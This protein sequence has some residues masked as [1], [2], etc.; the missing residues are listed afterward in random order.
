[1]TQLLVEIERFAARQRLAPQD[2]VIAAKRRAVAV[3]I[4]PL[5]SLRT[6]NVVSTTSSAVMQSP[7]GCAA[8][9]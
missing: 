3:G 2:S 6:S 9:I 7:Y 1:M 8:P 4:L 5:A